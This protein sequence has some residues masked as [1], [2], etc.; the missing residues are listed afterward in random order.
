MGL[1]ASN[2]SIRVN[3]AV[4]VFSTGD[5][6][7]NKGKISGTVLFKQYSDHVKVTLEL[8]GLKKNKK[9]GFHIHVNGDL[10]EGCKSCCS[11][12]NPTGDKHGG[13]RDIDSHAGDLGNIEGD[14]KGECNI[15]FTTGK[16]TVS[17]IVGRSL[18]I[19]EDEDDLGRGD[20]KDSDTTGHSGAR[21]ACA[22]IGIVS[23][24]C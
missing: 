13:L 8:K 21:I 10:R 23:E 1:G 20:E 5:L 12:Y 6:A 22:I 14:S 9:H 11:H 17:E 15:S 4:S 16:F 3:D 24:K 19:H 7:T 18:I 2:M